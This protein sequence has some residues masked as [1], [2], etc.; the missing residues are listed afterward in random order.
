MLGDHVMKL[1]NNRPW[2]IVLLVVASLD[3]NASAP[4]PAK[5]A[6]GVYAVVREGLTRDEVRIEKFSCAVLVY[7]RKY[8]DADKNE[9]PRYVALDT[10]SFVP[11]VLAGP[12]DAQKDDR[13]WTSLSVALAREHVRTLE[14]FTRVHLGGKVAIVIGGEVITIH[15]VQT[16]IQDGRARLT[17]CGDD[18]CKT[19]LLKL[20]KE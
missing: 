9:P 5:L 14:E 1:F 15:K 6:N 17:R 19:L 8:S 13:G 12:P 3:L 2:R 4:D 16:V 11:L 18:A 7:D 10:S 20:A